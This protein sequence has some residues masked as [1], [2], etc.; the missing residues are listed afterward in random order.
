MSQINIQRLKIARNEK[1]EGKE[2]GREEDL[3]SEFPEADLLI[4]IEKRGDIMTNKEEVIKRD[5]KVINSG[6]K[7]ELTSK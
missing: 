6:I 7:R 3:P 4:N 5:D 2:V 1:K